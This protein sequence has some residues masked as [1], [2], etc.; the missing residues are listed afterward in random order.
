MYPIGVFAYNRPH[1]LKL[2]LEAIERS[3][4]LLGR[5]LPTYIFCDYPK[6]EEQRLKVEETRKVAQDWGKA[7]VVLREKNFGFRNITEGISFLC[8]SYGQAIIIEDDIII[9]PDF[10]PFMCTSLEKYADD[11]EVFMIS[12]FIYFGMPKNPRCFFLP[13]AL[14]WGWATWQ[15]AWKHYSWIPLGWE[16]FIKDKKRKYLFDYFGSMKYSKMLELT[17]KGKLKTWDIQWSFIQFQHQGLCLCPSQS[18]IWNC[19][20]GG[21]THGSKELDNDPKKC[22]KEQYIHGDLSLEDFTEPRM[23]K[24]DIDETVFPKRR[25]VDKRAMRFLA[26]IFLRERIKKEGRKLPLYRRYWLQKL[27]LWLRWD[28]FKN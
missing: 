2:C 28:A 13:E 23:F 4:K 6:S 22:L 7:N 26:L 12:G 14:I 3:E 19:G 18:L 16:S 8:A 27:C 20:N 10:L 1:H 21:G 9:A 11:P 5:H 15:R 17:M 25:A 24:G